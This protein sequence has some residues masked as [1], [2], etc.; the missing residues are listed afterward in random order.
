MGRE[1]HVSVS[2]NDRNDGSAE[3]PFATI[4]RAAS[5]A[6]PGDV[7]TVHG[8]EYREWVKPENGGSS[9][10][11]RITYR[12]ASGEKVVIKGSERIENIPI[13]GNVQINFFCASSP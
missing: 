8:G 5:L 4:Q 2:G 10:F 6:M 3:R 7:V 12:A 11:N 9:E 13:Y 1:Y